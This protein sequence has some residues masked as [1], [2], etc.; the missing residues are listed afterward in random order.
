M[1]DGF[2]N[3]LKLWGIDSDRLR[4]DIFIPGSSERCV[5]RH[6]VEDEDG[7]LWV[8][9]RLF[10]RQHERRERIGRALGVLRAAGMP[11]LSYQAGRDGEYVVPESGFH[12]Q[13]APYV[14]GDPLPQPDFVD[15][16]ERGGHLAD[17]LISLRREGTGIREFDHEPDF[18]LPAYVDDLMRAVQSHKPELYRAL[19]PIREILT[20]FFETWDE[21]PRSLCHGD[22]HPLNVIWRGMDVAAVIDWEFAGLRPVLYDAA[23]CLGCVGIEDPD[24]LGNGLAP[25]MLRRMHH[26]GLLDDISFGWLPQLLLGLRFAW[27]SEWLRRKDSEMQ[28]LEVDY[29]SLLARN[30]EGLGRMWRSRME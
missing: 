15:H 24:A 13:L 27:M 1:Q 8:L 16:A 4:S 20:P 9:E 28:E 30:L 23:N 22:F 7:R 3:M 29:M 10:P 21:L 2:H 25:A 11:V 6:V 12:W 26:G 19:F 18:D 5:Q 14:P 17:F